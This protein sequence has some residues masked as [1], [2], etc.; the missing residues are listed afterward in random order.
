MN[1]IGRIL[2]FLFVFSVFAEAAPSAFAFDMDKMFAPLK[3]QLWDIA[4]ILLKLSAVVFGVFVIVRLFV[5]PRVT[6]VHDAYMKSRGYEYREPN[7]VK[8]GGRT[9]HKIETDPG[10][11]EPGHVWLSDWSDPDRPLPISRLGDF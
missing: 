4:V 11:E 10:E 9:Y 2:I 1:M 5:M 7:T 3:K 6:A 8:Y